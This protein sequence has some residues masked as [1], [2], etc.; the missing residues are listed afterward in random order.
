VLVVDAESA[1]RSQ[2][3]LSS[4]PGS[5][6]ISRYS[7]STMSGLENH[8]LTRRMVRSLKNESGGGVVLSA[9]RNQCLYRMAKT[10]Y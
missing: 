1:R 9:L 3:R 4:W 6:N 10:V 5:S 7:P 8:K 2:D